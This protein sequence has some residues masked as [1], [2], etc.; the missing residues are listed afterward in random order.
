M[1]GSIGTLIIILLWI[2]FNA[3]ILLTGFELDASI[4]NAKKN[5]KN[6]I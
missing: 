4:Y 3:I 1:Y 5:I 2:Y 6:K